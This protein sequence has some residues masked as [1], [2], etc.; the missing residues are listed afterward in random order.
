MKKI[1]LSTVA[2]AALLVASNSDYKYEVTPMVGKV[3]TGNNV[4]IKNHNT[5]GVSLGVNQPQESKF[6]QLEFG[7]LHT[8]NAKY[9]NS[10]VKTKITRLFTN[11]VKEY[12]MGSG[13]KFLGLAGVGYEAIDNSIAGNNSGA[14][15]EV[16]VGF[17]YALSKAVSLRAD[18]RQI[19]KFDGDR[20]LLY[21]L[22]LAIPFGKVAKPMTK[23]EPVMQIHEPMMKKV[24]KMKMVK[25]DSDKDGVYDD[26]DQCP[27]T[28]SGVK[29]TKYGCEYDLDDDSVVDSLDKCPSTQYGATVDANGCIALMKPANLGVLFD[30]NSAV[31]KDEDDSK[32]T[33]YVKYLNIEKK[34]K[35]LIEGHTDSTGSKKYNQKLSEN[36]AS[37]VK[38]KLVEMGVEEPRIDAKGYGE[39]KPLVDNKTKENRQLN[40]RVT[41]T[42]I[43]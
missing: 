24:H 26:V 34:A 20:D 28:N 16:G 7:I 1:V 11:V 21:T 12:D 19:L 27:N 6:D 23:E 40:R 33:K 18:V 25:I 30:T 4:D 17:K 42:I 3:I 32:F 8:T 5:F 39:T 43:K 10:N 9:E 38:A 37:S 2:T 36:R 29:V 31:I 41:A 15:A 13:F 14:F 35:I 22:G